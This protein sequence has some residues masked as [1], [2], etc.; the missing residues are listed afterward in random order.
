MNVLYTKIRELALEKGMSLAQL[1][2]ELNF[3]NGVIS[4]W[5]KGRASQDKIL[6]VANYFDVST[7]YLLG[8]T[9]IKKNNNKEL[10]VD[11]A[12]DNAMT[13]HGKP[14]TD[15]DREIIRGIV[16]AYLNKK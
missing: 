10:T 3:S 6:A 14:I 12:I 16:E 15:H 7:D 5:K 4:S 9:K 11:E 1:E 8:R 2:R 13:F